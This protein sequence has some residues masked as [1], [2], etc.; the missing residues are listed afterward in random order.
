MYL[1]INVFKIIIQYTTTKINFFNNNTYLPIFS[2]KNYKLLS[3]VVSTC[4]LSSVIIISIKMDILKCDHLNCLTV[5]GK[6]TIQHYR[7][8]E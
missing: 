2:I 1:C 3:N 4:V 7:F 8:S 5:L 6:I